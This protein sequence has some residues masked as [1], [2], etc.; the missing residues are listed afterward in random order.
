MKG[1]GRRNRRRRPARIGFHHKEEAP[2]SP[3]Q[4]WRGEGRIVHKRGQL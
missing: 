2:E 4:G 1:G 3:R